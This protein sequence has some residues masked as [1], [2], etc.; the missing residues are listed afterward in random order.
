MAGTSNRLRRRDPGRRAR[1]ADA[2]D[3][4]EAASARTRRSSW[5][6]KREGPAPEAAFKVGES[7]VE[8]SA[9][10]FARVCGMK[11]H[12]ESDQLE[13]AGLRFFF[14][15]GDNSDITQRAEWG[16]RPSRPCPPTSSTAAASR[17]RSRAHARA[18]RG[19]AR[20]LP[21]PGRGPRGRRAHRHASP[22]GDAEQSVRARWV[23]DG[24][25]ARLHPQEQARAREGG[26]PHDQLGLVAGRERVRRPRGL[27]R[28]RRRVDGADGAAG[29]PQAQHQPPGRRG[30]LGL[31]DPARLELALDR[32][33]GR[34]ALPPVR[35]ASPTF[36]AAMDWLR[37]HEPQLAD[38]MDERRDDVAGLPQGRG[39][40]ARLRA[41][42]LARP[43][44]AHGRGRRLPRPALLAGLR[45]HQL[46]NIYA[47]GPDQARPRTA[48]TSLSWPRT[49]TAASSGCSRRCSTPCGT[50]TTRS[51]ATPR[52]SRTR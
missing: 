48:R 44:G 28:P 8:I 42:L 13:K 23:V 36:D 40:R 39:L 37:E 14:P 3:P 41:R 35:A 25:R 38:A 32:H 26:G 7:T 18:G 6:E 4:V 16:D 27:G 49:T 11:D 46:A 51:S 47:D 20:R 22:S 12:I 33:R 15:A 50:T 10:Y 21:R 9:D 5:R 43:L 45:L 1:G 30:L 29:H 19:P 31:A 34:P 17:T 2:G 52:C 24:A